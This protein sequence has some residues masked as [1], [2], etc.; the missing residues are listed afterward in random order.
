MICMKV[1][2]FG[3]VTWLSFLGL[4]IFIFLLHYSG[5]SLRSNLNPNCESNGYTQTT[6]LSTRPNSPTL[7]LDVIFDS[8]RWTESTWSEG[9]FGNFD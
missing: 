7:Q 5:F 6:K 1:V 3:R 2:I 8:E 4:E 9:G